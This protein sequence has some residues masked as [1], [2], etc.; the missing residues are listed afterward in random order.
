MKGLH[1]QDEFVSLN[2]EI[3]NFE[4]ESHETLIREPRQHPLEGAPFGAISH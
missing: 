4:M 2:D 3:K 1:Q